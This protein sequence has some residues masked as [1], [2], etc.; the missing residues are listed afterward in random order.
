MSNNHT[1]KD[2]VLK[3]VFVFVIVSNSDMLQWKVKPDLLYLVEPF[4][5]IQPIAILH[6]MI[7]WKCASF[8]PFVI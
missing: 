2:T 3:E 5:C 7:I 1:I 4:S 6:G 8:S